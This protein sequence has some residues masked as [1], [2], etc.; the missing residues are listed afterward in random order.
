MNPENKVEADRLPDPGSNPTPDTSSTFQVA[1]KV[2]KRRWTENND[3][4]A[5]PRARSQSNKGESSFQ[6]RRLTASEIREKEKKKAYFKVKNKFDNWRKRL[7][8]FDPRDLDDCMPGLLADDI[9]NMRLALTLSLGWL[10]LCNGQSMNVSR[11]GP[12]IS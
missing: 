5:R 3:D 7:Q 9:G 4:E 2:E 8:I 6:R 11:P 1:Q 12:S 10:N